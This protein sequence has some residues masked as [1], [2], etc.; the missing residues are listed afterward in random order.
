M[1]GWALADTLLGVHTAEP[2]NR[3]NSRLVLRAEGCC[4]TARGTMR[5]S[6]AHQPA[7]VGGVLR[8]RAAVPCRDIK[9]C[10]LLLFSDGYLKLADLGCCCLLPPGIDNARTRTGSRAYM[11]PEVVDASK[12]DGYSFPVDM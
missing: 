3:C 8:V 7:D 9:P 4:G 10:N 6:T 2:C 1:A 5:S 11:A 12:T